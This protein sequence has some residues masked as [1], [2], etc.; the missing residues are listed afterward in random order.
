MAVSL[1]EQSM[2][3]TCNIPLPFVAIDIPSGKVRSNY[4]PSMSLLLD[5]LIS[6]MT[7]WPRLIAIASARRM[8]EAKSP[9]LF[10]EYFLHSFPC[11]YPLRRLARVK[12]ASLNPK[13]DLGLKIIKKLQ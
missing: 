5:R 7:L 4:T 2:V 3:A 1:F 12:L 9:M 11:M 10:W 6:S 8:L 13:L